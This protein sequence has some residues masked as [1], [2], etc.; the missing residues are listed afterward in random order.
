MALLP[1][2]S[3]G[4]TGVDP[5]DGRTAGSPNVGED[6]SAAPAR[7]EASW[8]D[9]VELSTATSAPLSVPTAARTATPADSVLPPMAT[10]E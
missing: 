7:A 2:A 1:I 8:P 4:A 10:P 9:G 3:P 6:A 5:V